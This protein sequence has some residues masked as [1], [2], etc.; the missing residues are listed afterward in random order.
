MNDLRPNVFFFFC[1]SLF[2]GRDGPFSA[3]VA[4]LYVHGSLL[5]PEIWLLLVYLSFLFFFISR[6]LPLHAE[7]LLRGQQER[8][9]EMT[10]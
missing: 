6:Y 8:P 9:E 10:C 4:T 7:K 5:R 3:A 2:L 1:F